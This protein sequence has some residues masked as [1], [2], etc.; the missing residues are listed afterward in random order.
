MSTI[1][2]SYAKAGM[3]PVDQSAIGKSPGPVLLYSESTTDSSSATLASCES[4]TSSKVK[5]C[6]G[7][8][9]PSLEVRN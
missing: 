3:Y 5:S 9:S 2:N 8:A 6:N 4:S 1:V 7:G